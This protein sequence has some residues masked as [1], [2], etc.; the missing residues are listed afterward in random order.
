M[1]L[2]IHI[3]YWKSEILGLL[4]PMTLESQV[5]IFFFFGLNLLS[6]EG[7]KKIGLDNI[8]IVFPNKYNRITLFYQCFSV[9][10]GNNLVKSNI[11]NAEE[12]G[13]QLGW[14]SQ[15]TYLLNSLCVSSCVLFIKLF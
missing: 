5:T 15:E 6:W 3:L 4:L 8:Q 12:S 13:R 2:N 14:G 1:I 10:G 11:L 7:N 9:F